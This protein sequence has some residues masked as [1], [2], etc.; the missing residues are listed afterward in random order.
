ML[1][2][3]KYDA[4]MSS[5]QT[6]LDGLRAEDSHVTFMLE[7]KR[8]S[9][10]YGL[11]RHCKLHDVIIFMHGCK[12]SSSCDRAFDNLQIKIQYIAHTSRFC[13]SLCLS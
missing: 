6:T 3:R 10:S 5:L 1:Q 13:L 8:V 7:K 12:C 4:T 9:F 11:K 2:I